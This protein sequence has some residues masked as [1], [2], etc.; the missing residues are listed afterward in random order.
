MQRRNLLKGIGLIAGGFALPE[1]TLAK[2]EK[3]AE[4]VLRIAHLTDIHIKKGIRAALGFEKCLHH[5]QNLPDK[6]DMIIN[7]GDAVM[8]ARNTSADKSTR[9]WEIFHQVLKSENG[10]PMISCIGNHDIWCKQDKVTAF[11]DGKARALELLELQRSYF[12]LDRNGWHIIVLDSIHAKAEGA[13]YTALLDEKQL[14]WLR[15]D[16]QNTDKKIP[17]LV[18]SHVPILSACVF[19]DGQN[20]RNGGWELPGSWM[21]TDCHE[22]TKLFYSYPNVKLAISGHI[23]LHDKVE[24]N[25]ITYCCNGAVSGNYWFGKYRQTKPGYAMIDLYADGTF[26]NRYVTY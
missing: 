25:N 26:N 21:H 13:G 12:S 24:Y 9:E 22:L 5:V 4:P 7:G 11:Y 6:P 20:V 2:G 16:L 17:I 14:A 3:D 8:G 10:L 23:H 19:L 18:V 15:A 1:L